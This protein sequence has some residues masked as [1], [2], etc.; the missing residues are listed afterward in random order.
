MR[1]LHGVARVRLLNELLA[2][3]HQKRRDQRR[4]RW[5]QLLRLDH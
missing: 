4:A 3:R 5:R 2:E 1:R